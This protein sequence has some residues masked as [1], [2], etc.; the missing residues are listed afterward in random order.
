MKQ[1]TIT[2]VIALILFI[3]IVVA[4]GYWIDWLVALLAAVAIAEVFLMKK[5]ILFSIDFI[6]ALL[7]TI[8]WNVPASFFDILFP[9][10][11]IT[12][13][14][15][16]FACVMLLLTWTVLSK[17]KTNFDDVGVYTLASLYIGSGFHYLS[18]I[19]NI[20]HTSILGLALLGYV[21]AIV[22]ST[23]IGAYLV[24]KQFGKHKLWPVISPNKTW[25][26]SI[27]AVVCALVISA[28]YVSLVPHLHGHLELIFASIFFSIV[29]QMGDLVESAYKRYYGVKDS[30]KILPGHGG[31]LDRFDS[32]LFVLPVVALFLGIK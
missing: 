25:E 31:I 13:A 15:V 10:K 9:Q 7:A 11:N 21:F 14:G 2:A 4:G 30:G 26:G 23:D 6:L 3:P 29:G 12:R 17:N 27:G 19:R 20:N 28:I 8:T 22:W 18:A 16:Y 24:G 32:M 1:R 5:Q